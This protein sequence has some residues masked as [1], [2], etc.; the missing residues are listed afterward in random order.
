[1][2]SLKQQSVKAIIWDFFGKIAGQ[3]VM[4]IISIFL[5][6]LLS[7][8]DF[9][10][11]AMVN[12][13]IALSTSLIDMGLGVA[14]IQRKEVLDAHYGSVFFFNIAVGIPYSSSLRSFILKT[15]PIELKTNNRDITLA[16]GSRI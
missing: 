5:A 9:G 12:V 16:I 1:M 13:F 14:I 7:A 4:F 8:Q 6:R 2:T 11:L 10:L 15:L 3:T